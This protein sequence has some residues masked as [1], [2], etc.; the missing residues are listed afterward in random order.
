MI[1]HGLIGFRDPNG[2]RPLILGRRGF[3][4]V[5]GLCVAAVAV[6]G[7]AI[8]ARQGYIYVRAEYPLAIQMLRTAIDRARRKG[9]LGRNILGTGFDFDIDI[10]PGAGAFVCGE[11]TALMF[12]IAGPN[13]PTPGRITPDAAAITDGSDVMTES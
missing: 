8:G 2:I 5:T 13:A 11:S 10:Y 4:K 7:Y 3:L 6:C 12:S 1:G 9:F